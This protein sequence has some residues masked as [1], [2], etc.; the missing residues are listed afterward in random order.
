MLLKILREYVSS[1]L[2]EMS[3]E[4]IETSE[5][6]LDWI[7]AAYQSP[8]EWG[9]RDKFEAMLIAADKLNLKEVGRGSSRIVFDL[10]NNRVIKIASNVAGIEQNTLEAAAGRDPQV[11]KILAGV[12]EFADEF[13][14]VLADKVEPL[15]N[16]DGKRAEAIAGIEWNTL[17]DLVSAGSNRENA[18]T[19]VEG[20]ASKTKKTKNNSKEGAAGCLKGD[21]FLSAVDYF[22]TR[23]EDLLPGDIAKLSSWGVTKKGCLVL[24]DYGITTKKFKELYKKK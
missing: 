22:M 23:Y 6:P 4:D 3:Q 14:W 13:S 15:E 18:V 9:A 10:G 1:Q 11:E 16:G 7:T 21:A 24:L 17:R 8:E 2:L 12:R 19:S 20:E 5:D